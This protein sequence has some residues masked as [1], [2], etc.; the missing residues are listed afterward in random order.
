M[1]S[2]Q[3]LAD[4]SVRHA[5]FVQRYG[6]GQS[7]RAE[8]LLLSLYDEIT[9]RLLKESDFIK[10]ARLKLILKDVADLS[11]AS[12]DDISAFIHKGNAEFVEQEALFNVDLYTRGTETD[13]I[14]P[15]SEQLEFGLKNRTMGLEGGEKLTVNDAVNKFSRA[16][17]KQI[18]N[19]IKNGILLGDSTDN[20]VKELS[21][22]LQS[23]QRR[24][25]EALV[26]TTT[27]HA[28]TVARLEVM[29]ANEDILLGYRALA[30]LDSRTTLI[31]MG[32]DGK[33]FALDSGIATPFHWGCR[34]CLVP[35]VKPEYNVGSDLTGERFARDKDGKR[36]NVS[37]KV[38]Y[39]GWLKR[40]PKE[41]QDEVLG[42]NRA[43]MFRSGKVSIENFTGDDGKTLTL[44]Q[45]KATHDL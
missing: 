7:K 29:K 23:L 35:E 14:M 40:Q 15:S 24:Q 25:V 42:V 45:L 27:N 6:G 33:L 44:K 21:T 41:F 28:A 13:F 38:T 17:Q 12:F 8:K 39:G 10:Q 32:R 9:A 34:T 26:R 16:K 4:A 31:C 20:I 1:S 30:T 43:K 19:T 5:V 18:R 36:E 3:Y 22:T 2:R 11:K 37:D